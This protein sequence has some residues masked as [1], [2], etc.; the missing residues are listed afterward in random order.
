[1]SIHRPTKKSPNSITIFK[2]SYNSIYAFKKNGIFMRKFFI[3]HFFYDSLINPTDIFNCNHSH[4]CCLIISSNTLPSSRP[5]YITMHNF[6][7]G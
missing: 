4:R 1:M 6:E 2:L 3:R 7:K 5:L